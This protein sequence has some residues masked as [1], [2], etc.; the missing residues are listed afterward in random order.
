MHA[1]ADHPVEARGSAVNADSDGTRP[2]RWPV[3]TA[4]TSPT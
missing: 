3:T 1:A 2:E 4:G